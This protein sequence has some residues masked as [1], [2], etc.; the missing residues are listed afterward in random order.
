MQVNLSILRLYYF[1]AFGAFG[2]YLPYF[3]SWLRHRGFVGAE[4]SALVTMLPLCQLV[5]PTLVGVLSDRWGLRGRMM[6]FCATTTALGMTGF[7]VS[8]VSIENLPLWLAWLCAIMFSALRGPSV[9]LADVLAMEHAPN[10][11]RTRLWGSLGFLTFAFAGGHIIDIAHPFQLPAYT[12]CCLWILVLVSFLLPKTTHL[13]PR[14]AISDA[15]ELIQQKSY[16]T[17]LITMVLIFG[18]MSAYD[19][20][21]SLQLDHLGASSSEIGTFW[22]IAT[23][24]EVVLLFFSAELVRRIGPGKLLTLACFCGTGRWI[25]L[26]Q[27]TDLKL[28]LVM[29]P[30]HALS[31]GLM[32]VSA[33]GVLKRELGNKGTATAHGLYSSAI[34]IGA[35]MGLFSWGILF[36]KAG[37]ATVFLVAAGLVAIA[38]LSASRLIRTHGATV[39]IQES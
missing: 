31:F 11:G 28:I 38:T 3:P 2:L 34:A 23:L 10:Y 29:Q 1:I 9:G 4:M 32:W 13:P 27:A 5:A 14:P 20:C 35:T 26:S 25:F 39:L 22:T 16:R 36:E 8:A 33:I 17:L 7:M 6:S 24:S 15:K 30:L 37:G 19:L 12:A 21:A 18:G